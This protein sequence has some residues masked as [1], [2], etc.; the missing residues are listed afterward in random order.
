VYL[1]IHNT[2]LL[3]QYLITHHSSTSVCTRHDTQAYTSTFTQLRP[4]LSNWTSHRQEL[5]AAHAVLELVLGI[6]LLTRLSI[7]VL[8]SHF[9]TRAAFCQPF[10][11]R[12]LYCILTITTA[13]W[14]RTGRDLNTETTHNKFDLCGLDVVVEF[15]DDV[16]KQ[17]QHRRLLAVQLRVHK[18][19]PQPTNHVPVTLRHQRPLV[20]TQHYIQCTLD[21]TA[22]PIISQGTK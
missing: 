1:I 16:V 11:K 21:T 15:V 9:C 14:A 10:N 7:I 4:P 22:G 13:P 19:R 18:C 2:Q 5:R 12:I 8:S 20:F 3:V 17:F 6:D